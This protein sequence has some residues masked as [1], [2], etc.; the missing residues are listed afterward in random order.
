MI[1]SIKNN[2]PVIP[3]SSLNQ[4]QKNRRKVKHE[5][6]KRFIEVAAGSMKIA[7]HETMLNDML[8]TMNRKYNPNTWTRLAKLV[9]VLPSLD[10]FETGA[11]K[12]T[13]V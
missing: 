5:A 9:D 7:E 6:L 11:K 2:S 1:N 12:E 3:Y 4:N 8:N 10:P 13:S